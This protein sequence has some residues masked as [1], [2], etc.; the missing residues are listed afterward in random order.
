M[1]KKLIAILFTGHVGS[2]WLLS[3]MDNHPRIRQLG[4][5]P[6]DDLTEIDVEATPYFEQVIHGERLDSLPERIAVILGKKFEDI[7]SSVPNNRDGQS[8]GDFD[9]IAFKARVT[10]QI[11][12][13]FFAQWLPAEKPTI[14]L[15]RRRNKIKNAVSQFKRTQL[16]ISH[17]RNFDQTALKRRPII[18]DP[19]YILDQASQFTL[20]EL[21]TTRYFQKVCAAFDIRGFEIS[22]EELLSQTSREAFLKNFYRDIGLQNST[23]ASS[24][25]CKITS[26]SL[27]AAVENYRQLVDR[28]NGTIFEPCLT[29]DRYDVVQEILAGNV[30]F[31]SFADDKM[32]AL[33]DTIF[34]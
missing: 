23:S 6:V 21:R 17:L 31:P 1:P 8:L 22:Y 5:E 14:I 32:L 18:V 10:L 3:L 7:E 11:Q 25:Y 19:Q 27:P 13:S 16:N 28:I 33:I 4:F 30:D 20:R 15:L 2:S 26:D 24:R 34:G 29:N 9:Y 12:R